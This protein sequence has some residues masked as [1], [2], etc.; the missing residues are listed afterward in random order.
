MDTKKVNENTTNMLDEDP[1]D[2]YLRIF[3]TNKINGFWVGPYDIRVYNNIPYVP[4]KD[5]VN[6]IDP[7]NRIITIIKTNNCLSEKEYKKKLCYLDN[8]GFY[9]Y[10]HY[11]F[12]RDKKYTCIDSN[13]KL[14]FYNISELYKNHN[15]KRI[16]FFKC[17]IL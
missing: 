15:K 4:A 17:I 14:H 16:N 1:Y 6:Q 13:R 9:Y 5:G 12:Y 3:R 7:F 2:K 10:N 8:D 11:K